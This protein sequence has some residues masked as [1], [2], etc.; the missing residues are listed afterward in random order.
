MKKF[1]ESGRQRK[2]ECIIISFTMN[3]KQKLPQKKDAPVR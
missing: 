2:M 1:I 3:F